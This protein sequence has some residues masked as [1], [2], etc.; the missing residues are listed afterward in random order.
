MCLRVVTASLQAKGPN[1]AIS[2]VYCVPSRMVN[3]DQRFVESAPIIGVKVSPS[4]CMGALRRHAMSTAQLWGA[5]EARPR[6]ED[7]VID[8]MQAIRSG[9][10]SRILRYC[11]GRLWVLG[12]L[13]TRGAEALG[14]S[15]ARR[16]VPMQ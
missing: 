15:W 14:R 4:C 12:P 2:M 5:Q 7:S 9:E 13:D 8:R 3:H 10:K 6:R 1:G 16:L 11:K